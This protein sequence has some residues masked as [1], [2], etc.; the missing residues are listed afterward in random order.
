MTATPAAEPTST[1]A[2]TR[3]SARVS[4]WPRIQLRTAATS[5]A[6]AAS[7]NTRP[8]AIFAICTRP[9]RSRSA[10]SHDSGTYT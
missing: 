4:Q 9:E 2:K 10:R 6:S 7:V 8:T 1:T 3:A 5:A